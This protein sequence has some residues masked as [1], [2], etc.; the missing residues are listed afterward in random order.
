MTQITFGAGLYGVD[1]GTYGGKPAVFVTPNK[2][3]APIG[4]RVPLELQAPLSRDTLLD[5]ETVMIFPTIE[6]CREVADA[7]V[8]S[9]LKPEGAAPHDLHHAQPHPRTFPLP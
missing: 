9:S 8:G 1:I 6:R 2:V 5:G 7:L 4:E 3:A